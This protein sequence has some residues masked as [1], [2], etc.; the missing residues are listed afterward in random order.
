VSADAGLMRAPA[1]SIT[2]K[3]RMGTA[4]VDEINA[5]YNKVLPELVNLAHYYAGMVNI[6]F[7]NV[8]AMI[9]KQINTPEF[10]RQA[11]QIIAD[12]ITAAEAVHETPPEP[13]VAAKT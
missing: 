12:A 2:Q 7:V 8:S 9:D 11:V 6:P 4:S 10:K 1:H 5:A 13:T 3:L